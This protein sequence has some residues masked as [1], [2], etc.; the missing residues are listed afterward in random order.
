MHIH[1]CN[2]VCNTHTYKTC[3]FLSTTPPHSQKLNK[4]QCNTTPIDQYQQEL[5]GSQKK[6]KN[7]TIIY[8][9]IT[10]QGEEDGLNL[11]NRFPVP[12]PYSFGWNQESTYVLENHFSGLSP[13]RSQ[14]NSS[15]AFLTFIRRT[16]AG[17]KGEPQNSSSS[18][19][20]IP[21]PFNSLNT[22]IYQFQPWDH[23]DYSHCGLAFI[24]MSLYHQLLQ[25]IIDIWYPSS[26]YF[27]TFSS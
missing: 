18:W 23:Q 14:D 16:Q 17:I 27:I 24:N 12:N 8:Q 4:Y 9:A 13:G 20:D 21:L 3:G 10:P 2:T 6:L 11:I 26:H 22:A 19:E 1:I 25:F 15:V 7:K 5:K